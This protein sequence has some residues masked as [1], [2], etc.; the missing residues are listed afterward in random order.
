MVVFTIV[1]TI[2]GY[3]VP[4]GPYQG[5]GYPG[6]Q[7]GGYG[8]FGGIGGLGG[9]FGGGFGGGQQFGGAQQFAGAGQAGGLPI[10]VGPQQIPIAAGQFYPG[11]AGGI[12][13]AGGLG[14]AGGYGGGGG[15]GVGGIPFPQAGISP[16]GIGGGF[17]QPRV[18]PVG[19][20]P[21][22]VVEAAHGGEF[23]DKKVYGD[24]K[25]NLKDA[26]FEAA[27][28]K[29]GEEFEESEEGYKKEKLQRR[30]LKQMLDITE[31]K[32]ERRN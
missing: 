22:P 6:I 8:G 31:K 16:V 9:E 29:K 14:G 26:K 18:G 5:F 10:F 1:A 19:I 32:K 28:G 11:L 23:V 30:M 4:V 7:Q 20:A 3:K 2:N 21:I 27:E 15:I 24:E 17:V 13:G 25:K 12:G